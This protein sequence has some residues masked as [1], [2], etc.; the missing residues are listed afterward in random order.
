VWEQALRTAFLRGYDLTLAHD[1]ERL[2]LLALF[3]TERL[4]YELGYELANRP[5]WAW[6]PLAGIAA[7]LPE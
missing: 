5:D 4:F 1:P 7:L 6:I 3:E 2:R